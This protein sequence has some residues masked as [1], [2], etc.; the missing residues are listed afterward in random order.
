MTTG[1]ELWLQPARPVRAG[2]T[3]RMS[4][5]LESDGASPALSFSESL[6]E[7]RRS[8]DTDGPGTDDDHRVMAPNTHRNPSREYDEIVTCEKISSQEFLT[9]SSPM[10]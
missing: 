3:Q 10:R 7:Q 5:F 6:S 4:A 8:R 9:N 2:D 1:V